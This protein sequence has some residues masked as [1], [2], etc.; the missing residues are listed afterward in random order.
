MPAALIAA[1]VSPELTIAPADA[2]CE[3]VDDLRLIA[4][5]LVETDVSEDGW[6]P[7][8][9]GAIAGVSEARDLLGHVGDTYRPLVEDLVVSFE[10]LQA[11]AQE[12]EEQETA[13]AK[14]ATIGESIT[15]IGDSMDAL[16]VQLRAG[17][18]TAE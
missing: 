17:C 7:V 12:L 2:A 1:E 13:G 8:M 16:S 15:G 14:L 6:L 4:E 3:S 10:G 9:V 5:F 18:S 11:A